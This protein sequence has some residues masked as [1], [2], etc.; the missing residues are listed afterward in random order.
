MGVETIPYLRGVGRMVRA[1]GRRVADADEPEM[2]ELLR[3][4]ETVEL[5]V[6][7][8]VDGWRG[9]GRSWSEIGAAMGMSKQAAAQRFGR[10]EAA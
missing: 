3:L 5:A 8:A 7:E 4:R 2:A 10:K 9:M 6:Q 1:A